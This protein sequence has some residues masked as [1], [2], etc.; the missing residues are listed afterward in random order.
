MKKYIV[1]IF[2]AIIMMFS[3]CSSDYRNAIPAG[4]IAL[5]SLD[6]TNQDLSQRLNILSDLLHISDPKESGIDFREKIYLFETAEGSLGL[7]AKVADDQKIREMFVKL[8]KEGIAHEEA[9]R[10]KCNFFTVANKFLVGYT[11]DAI[12]ILGP[13]VPAA[14]GEA[15]N[16]VARY[17]NQKDDDGMVGTPMLEKL[18]SLSAPMC[19]VTQATALP[20]NIS[21]ILTIGLPKDI[22]PSQ[23]ILAANITFKD[24]NMYVESEPTSFSKQ[25]KTKLQNAYSVLRPISDKYLQTLSSKAL[26]G[27]FVNVKG[28]EF[29]P[30]LQQSQSVW[31]LLAG[32]NAAIDMNAILKSID[33]NV[34]ISVPSYQNNNLSISLAAEIANSNFLADVDYWKQSVPKGGKITNWQKDA[35][36]YSGDGLTF[37]FGVTSGDKKEFYSGSSEHEASASIQ[38]TST[39]LSKDVI[40]NIS[41]KRLA[42]I[43]GISALL[44]EKSGMGTMMLPQMIHLK[45]VIYTVK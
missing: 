12:V 18:D 15:I 25:L 37:Y 20:Q 40:S 8:E 44:P 43:V 5:I 26:M 31:T 45:N 17:L 6:A 4:S 19:I 22:D 1:F 14:K 3:S 33:G 34:L 36:C 27:M 29:L 21:S 39:P 32:I 11:N 13:I 35:Y 28:D 10:Q 24:D 23:C 2:A 38:K 42:V 9:E 7:C 30:L 16:Q 41:G